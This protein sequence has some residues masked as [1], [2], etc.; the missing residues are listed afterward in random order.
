MLARYEVSFDMVSYLQ[1]VLP[2]FIILGIAVL[3]LLVGV[4]GICGVFSEN[5]CLLGT[6][7]IIP[8]YFYIRDVT[9]S[10]KAYRLLIYLQ[11]ILVNISLKGVL[12]MNN[13]I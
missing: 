1:S 13:L 9:S 8:I 4:I 6:V 5:R 3:M 10:L 11:S 12:Y 7:R 2:A